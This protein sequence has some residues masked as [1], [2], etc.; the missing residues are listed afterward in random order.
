MQ[1]RIAD[2]LHADNGRDLDAKV[3]YVGEEQMNLAGQTWRLLHYKLSGKANV[4][5]WYEFDSDR[6]AR[7]EWVEDGHKTVVELS[8]IRK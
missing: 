4:D 2:G 6:L 5:L 3:T 7:Q 1:L 8:K